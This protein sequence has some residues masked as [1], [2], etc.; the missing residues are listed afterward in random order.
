MFNNVQIFA[1]DQNTWQLT[2]C[3]R[4]QQISPLSIYAYNFTK[5]YG[6]TFKAKIQFQLHVKK[7]LGRHIIV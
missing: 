7:E 5:L 2:A 6:V 3:R 1:N 4:R